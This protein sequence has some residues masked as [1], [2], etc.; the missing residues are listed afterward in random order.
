MRTIDELINRDDP[1]WPVVQEMLQTATNHV[2][3]LEPNLSERDACLVE[4]QVTTRSLLGA[5]IYETGG[6]LVD[7]GWIRILGSGHPKLSRSI[8]SWNIGKSMNAGE[9][10]IGFFLIAD[11]VIGGFYAINSGAFGTDFGN[12]YYFAP[13]SLEWENMQGGHTQ[14]LTWCFTTDLNGWYAGR[15]WSG[16]EEEAASLPGDKGW[17]YV[18]PLWLEQLPGASERARGVVSMDELYDQYTGD[19]RKQKVKFM[20]EAERLGGS[21]VVSLRPPKMDDSE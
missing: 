5:I 12:M 4:A 18:P 15:R 2:E 6:L 3:V 14:F 11:D 10:T 17:C 13:D 8:S 7:H 9:P 19:D 21:I 20:K 16:W 1:G